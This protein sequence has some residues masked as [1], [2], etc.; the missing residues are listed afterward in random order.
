MLSRMSLPLKMDNIGLKKNYSSL[1][2]DNITVI[3][4][5]TSQSSVVLKVIINSEKLS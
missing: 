4:L 3:K 2:M 1:K 5:N